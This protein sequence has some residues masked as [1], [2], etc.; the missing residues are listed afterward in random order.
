[1]VILPNARRLRRDVAEFE[2]AEGRFVSQERLATLFAGISGF[3]M[4]V[5]LDLWLLFARLLFVAEPQGVL[6][7]VQRFHWFMLAL[8]VVTILGAVAGS[9]GL[10]LFD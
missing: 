4:I 9:H 6:G 3:Y 10:V 2:H 7:L 8:S 1:M 5:R